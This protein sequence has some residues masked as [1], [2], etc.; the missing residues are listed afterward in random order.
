MKDKLE[1]E[2][3]IHRSK[4]LRLAGI[5]ILNEIVGYVQRK[6]FLRIKAAILLIQKMYKV[7][8]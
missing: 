4:N 6:K 3:E 5:V 7:R 2:I 1:A 8:F